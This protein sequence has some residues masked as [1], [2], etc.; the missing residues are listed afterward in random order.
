MVAAL[1][2]LM[3]A[4]IFTMIKYAMWVPWSY[5]TSVCRFIWAERKI[6]PWLNY[7]PSLLHLWITI[8]SLFTHTANLTIFLTLH[9]YI[10]S[11][12]R[13]PIKFKAIKSATALKILFVAETTVYRLQIK[14]VNKLY[15]WPVH[16]GFCNKQDFK[17]SNSGADHFFWY[18]L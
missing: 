1:K 4:S 3:L 7:F 13:M 15:F 6:F 17:I 10:T 14:W 16:F 9:G 12:K 18:I 11:L 5:D 2:P 8:F